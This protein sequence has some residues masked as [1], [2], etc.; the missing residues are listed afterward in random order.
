M[1]IGIA[2]FA[3][4]NGRVITIKKCA[5]EEEAACVYDRVSFERRGER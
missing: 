3:Q 5:T 1:I 2:A 4:V